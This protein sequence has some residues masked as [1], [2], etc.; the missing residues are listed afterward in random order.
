MS[1]S[2]DANNLSELLA[3]KLEVVDD[4]IVQEVGWD[5][6]CDS[7][8]SEA[9][10][11]IIGSELIEE[12]SYE[13]SD[14][15]LFWFRDGDGDLTDDLVDVVSPLSDGGVVWLATPKVGNPDA[16]DPAEINESAQTA[17]LTQTSTATYENWTI[18]RLEQARMTAGR[19]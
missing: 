4:M 18:T 15:V 9:I 16:V 3:D 5:E 8:I 12:T 13:V 7:S 6:D 14:A 11:D 1:A 19:R 10:E 17:G 2:S